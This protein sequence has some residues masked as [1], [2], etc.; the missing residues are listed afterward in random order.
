VVMIVATSAPVRHGCPAGIICDSGRPLSDGRPYSMEMFAPPIV[1]VVFACGLPPLPVPVT[2]VF[3]AD[4]VP[5][6]STAASADT[7]SCLRVIEFSVCVWLLLLGVARAANRDHR[8]RRLVEVLAEPIE[9]PVPVIFE[10][11]LV[12]GAAGAV[13][14]TRIFHPHRLLSEPA[15]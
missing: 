5:A 9:H 7:Y 11:H 1:H 6:T 12:T 14:R 2:T 4:A 15:Q 13:A 3:C 8:R 10:L